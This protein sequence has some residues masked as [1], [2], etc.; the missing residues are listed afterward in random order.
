M[1]FIVEKK[2]IEAM[3]AAQ[4]HLKPFWESEES[5][6]DEALLEGE[7]FS[8]GKELPGDEALLDEMEFEIRISHQLNCRSLVQSI[9]DSSLSEMS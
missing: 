2:D 8:E 4:A 5:P 7:S 9:T 1:N 3:F 6:G